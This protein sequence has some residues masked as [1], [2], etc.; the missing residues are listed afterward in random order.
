MSKERHTDI[1]AAAVA[2]LTRRLVPFL[3]LLYIVAYLDRINVGFA[4]LQMQKQL[5]FSDA[6]YGLGAGIFFAGYFF[7]QI[8]SNLVLQRVGAR[9][10][11]SVLMIA[12]GLISSTTA[13]VST[14][15][16]FY[17]LRFL[18]GAAEAG[19]FPGVILYLKNWFPAAAQARTL[20][21]FMTAGPLSGV[22][23][24][25]IPPS[26]L[27]VAMSLAM[28]GPSSRGGPFWA[29]ANSLVSG[30]AAAAGI[31]FINSIGNL[32]GFFG[33]YIIGLARTSTGEFKGGLLVVGVTLGLTGLLALLVRVP[34]I[35]QT[36]PLPVIAN[37]ERN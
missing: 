11:I 15:K 14:P 30:S 20:A 21:W 3:F 13:F 10:W 18:L 4:A 34:T 5:G 9:R 27:I 6:V 35:M 19:F 12:W 37:T 36:G 7:F 28:V 22:L 2:N 33:P 29:M 25:P 24:G 8:P 32:G 23:G 26:V 1:G 31:A 16:S 17:F